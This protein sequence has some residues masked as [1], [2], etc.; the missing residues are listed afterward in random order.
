[1]VTNPD[2]NFAELFRYGNDA[3]SRSLEDSSSQIAEQGNGIGN[4]LGVLL[5]LALV[6]FISGIVLGIG[7]LIGKKIIK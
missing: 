1:M 4:I 3:L 6:L 5:V 7:W 2:V